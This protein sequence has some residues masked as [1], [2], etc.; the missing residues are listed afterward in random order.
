MRIRTGIRTGIRRRV[1]AIF[2]Y[3]MEIRIAIRFVANRTGIRTGNRVRVDGPL[4]GGTLRYIN[5]TFSSV[6][7][8]V[9]AVLPPP[10]DVRPRVAARV[11]RKRQ[12][13]TLANH[14]V[15]VQISGGNVRRN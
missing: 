15:S 12:I 1:D 11:A 9:L 14:K 5:A 8:D 10:H 7:H 4:K 2:S 13:S 3:C 6:H